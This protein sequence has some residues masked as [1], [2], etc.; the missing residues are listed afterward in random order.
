MDVHGLF[1][2]TSAADR[3][4]QH[5]V[6]GPESSQGTEI[7]RRF[8]NP[9]NQVRL[10]LKFRHLI[11]CPGEALRGVLLVTGERICL[12][13]FRPRIV[14]SGSSEATPSY[15]NGGRISGNQDAE[16]AEAVPSPSRGAAV[17]TDDK[18]PLSIHCGGRDRALE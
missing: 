17:D 9:G 11:E 12:S 4:Q 16:P 2:V 7:H 1:N 18:L 14:D 13:Q 8:H 10:F 15:F 6:V 3:H 5:R